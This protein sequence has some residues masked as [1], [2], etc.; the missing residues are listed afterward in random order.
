MRLMFSLVL[1]LVAASQCL[2]QDAAETVK[3]VN[4]KNAMVK[5]LTADVQNV[6]R[7]RNIAFTAQGKLYYEKDTNFRMTATQV[8][9]RQPSSDIGS[10]KDYFWFWVRRL[11][12]KTAYFS[13]YKNLYKTGMKD[14]LHPIWMMECLGLSQINTASARV[15]TSGPYVV[16]L[17]QD[18]NPKGETCLRMTCIDPK[19]LAVVEHRIYSADQQ[20]LSRAIIQD[21]YQT[22]A[23]VSLPKVICVTWYSESI[24]VTQTISN[25]QVNVTVPPDTWKMPN[26]GIGVVDIGK[27]RMS[28]RED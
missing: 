3:A 25:P 10:N 22:N 24:E 9:N 16:V 7:R 18:R 14:S 17:R 5:S 28:W 15:Y 2:S 27:N 19:R 26:F 11:D 4:A 21:S 12:S 13:T 23:G 1:W 8:T 20:L 6:T